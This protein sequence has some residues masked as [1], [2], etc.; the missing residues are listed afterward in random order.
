MNTVYVL[1][2]GNVG[3]RRAMLQQAAKVIEECCGNIIASSSIY[4]TAAW[5]FTAQP[6]FYNQAFAVHT[7][8]APAQFM[9][10]LLNMK[11]VWAG[12]EWKKWD[13]EP[14]IWIFY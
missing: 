4:K 7:A 14:L 10:T 3:N 12:C 13:R 6:H 2:G 1:A 5:G 8:L 9:Q 11:I